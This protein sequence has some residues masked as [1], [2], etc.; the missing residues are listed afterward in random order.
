MEAK[1]RPLLESYKLAKPYWTSEERWQAFGLLLLVLSL[2]VGGV[3][4]VTLYNTWD[5]E[6]FD[7]V[8]NLDK[9]AFL[10]AQIKWVWITAC[11]V[12]ANAYQSY[13]LQMLQNRWR[14]WMTSNLISEYLKDG[15]FYFCQ[16]DQKITDNP[17]Q[18]LSEDI[19]E[20]VNMSVTLFVGVF[21]EVLTLLTFIPILWKLSGSL[22]LS[23]SGRQMGI[24]GYMLWVCVLYTLF[25]T[26]IA[27][28]IGRKLIRLDYEQQK[29]EADFRFS[30]IRMRENA[31]SIN[32]YDG[33]GFEGKKL[34]KLFHPI[35]INFQYIM[36]KKKNLNFFTILYNRA[37][38]TISMLIAAPRLFSKEISFGDLMQLSSAFMQVQK[39]LSYFVTLYAEIAYWI[40][41]VQ[42]L[43]GF[44]NSIQTAREK[45]RMTQVVRSVS[46]NLKSIQVRQLSLHL[47]NQQRLIQSL[48]VDFE[49]G[50]H[51]LISG[52]SGSGKSTLFRAIAGIWPYVDGEIRIPAEQKL[53]FLPQRPYLPIATL[54]EVLTYPAIAQDLSESRIH[55]LLSI[56]KLSALEA[57]MNEIKNWNQVLSPGEQQRIAFIQAFLQKPDWLFLDESTSAIDEETQ[58]SIY[59]SIPRILPN[60]TYVSI[61]H[62][63]SLEKFHT[64]KLDL[65]HGNLM[66][67]ERCTVF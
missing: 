52:P 11:F 18:R 16:F 8:Q 31:E 56:C 67:I 58:N 43:T 62:R 23:L 59:G 4:T 28:L 7:A 32:L 27:H 50:K 35:F 45:I 9:N 20:F 2:T 38:A 42:R 57:K 10:K 3:Y 30:L 15:A 55:E 44:L 40:S 5:K 61:A 13:F 37:S 14:K 66:R 36:L 22:L 41:T 17:D 26:G 47:P 12:T 54:R 65:K 64:H 60:T 21:K 39:S 24:P 29:Y 33:T 1:L 53:L 63:S 25:G 51:L 34:S 19:R 48:N 6:F 46:Q 49:Q